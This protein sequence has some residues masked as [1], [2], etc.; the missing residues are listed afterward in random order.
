MIIRTAAIVTFALAGLPLS[1]SGQCEWIERNAYGRWSSHNNNGI[2][3][4]SHRQQTVL[5]A[6]SQ[7][8]QWHEYGW[9]RTFVSL[10]P[11][12]RSGQA[13]AYDA[14]RQRTLLFGG[15]RTGTNPVSLADTWVFDGTSWSELT[16]G[17]PA[18]RHEHAMAYD[19]ARQRIV[20]FGGNSSDG[21]PLPPLADTWEW[22]GT[23]WMQ[24]Q[25][26]VSPPARHGHAMVYDAARMRTI[27]FGG[28]SE[29]TLLGDTWEWD[30]NTWHLAA[31]PAPANPSARHG[32]RM[33]FDRSRQQTIL[34]AGE[35][36]SGRL[37]DTW[38]WDGTAWAQ[39][40]P[41]TVPDARAFH[42]MVYQ[43]HA[44]GGAGRILMAG[45][46]SG[47]TF[48]DLPRDTWEWDGQDWQIRTKAGPPPRILHSVLYDTVREETLVVNGEFAEPEGAVWGWNGE[49]W[50]RHSRGGGPSMDYAHGAVYDQAR[51]EIVFFGAT[52]GA[53]ATWTWNGTWTHRAVQG[54]PPIL[55]PFMAYDAARQRT[56]VYGGTLGTWEWDGA[57][58]MQIPIPGVGS[59]GIMT[60]DS[61][62][63]RIIMVTGAGTFSYDGMQ[64]VQLADA[65]IVNQAT[66]IAF[67]PIRNRTVIFGMGG[68][69]NQTWEFDG[70]VWSRIPI[71]GPRGRNMTGMAW[72]ARRERMVL[73]GGNAEGRTMPVDDTWELV[74]TPQPCYANCDGSTMP[75]LLNIDDFSCYINMF[76]AAMML[77]HNQQVASYA[78][79][80]GS[81][82][83]PALN[84][85]DFTC[86]INAFAIG[87]R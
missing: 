5:L 3:Y 21:S 78:N 85:D 87:C 34:F 49:V 40:S 10:S 50:R 4:D 9:S 53:A 17:S 54:P 13:M 67:D 28:R 62:Q 19:S 83:A 37:G 7:T 46:S 68:W 48:E 69:M 27:I 16:V 51:G 36:A 18:A 42:A 24:R 1:A 84:V 74:C 33:V 59:P 30:G 47:P 81:T 8:W 11:V 12:S 77:P 82:V 60:F 80:D 70:E 23:G 79:C 25:P 29:G 64:W 58:W 61:T 66:A 15:R 14:A 55:W 75:P 43:E 6:G 73:F 35:D 44:G 63:N 26:G 52:G 71:S 86:F 41:A 72:D 39:Q 22:D 65:N 56:V 2:A 57:Q 31:A 20:L 38:A 32:H 76:A 45:G